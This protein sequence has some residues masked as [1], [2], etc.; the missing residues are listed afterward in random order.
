MKWNKKICGYA[1]DFFV[2]FG[3][4]NAIG[5]LAQLARALAWHARG[6][7][8]ESSTAHYEVVVYWMNAVTVIVSVF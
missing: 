1:V 2:H 5:R 3:I 7:W 8:F 6:H 4:I